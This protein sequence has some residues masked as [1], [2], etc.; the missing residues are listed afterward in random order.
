MLLVLAV[1]PVRAARENP[2]SKVIELLDSLTAKIQKE[3]ENED[4]AFKEF[5]AWCKDAATNTGFEIKTATTQKEK[6]SADIDK[7]KGDASAAE[8]KIEELA[9]GISTSEAD[10]KAAT[11][12][13][14][15]ESTNFAKDEAE[16]VDAIDTLGRAIKI[17]E[18][19]MAKNPAAFAQMDT[20]NVNGLVKALSTVVDAAGFSSADKQR[21]TALVQSKDKDEDELFGAP[22]ADVYKS[23]SGGILDVLEDLKEKAEEQLSQ[24]RKAETNAKHNYEMLKQSLEDQMGA[25]TKDLNEEKQAL[26]AAKEGQATSEKDLAMTE[27]SLADLESKLETAQ[28]DCQ[29]TGADHEASVASRAEELKAIATAKKVL[30]D[31]TAGAETQAYSLLQLN[32]GSSVSSKLHT[33]ADLANIEVVT[34]VK[35]LAKEYHSSA[36][37][38]LASRISAVVKYGSAAG[39]DPFVKVKALI[40]D[41]IA[42][43]EAEASSEADEKAYCDDQMAKTEEKKQELEFDISKLT[44]KIDVASS[45]SAALKEDVKELQADLATLAKE[46]LEMD[47][48]RS[49]THANY[50]QAKADLEAGLQGV[51]KALSVLREYYGSGAAAAMIQGTMAQPAVPEYHEKASGAGSSIIGLLEV[52]ESDF[53]KSLA[54]EETEESDAQTQYEKVSQENEISKTMKSQDVTYKVKEFKSLD[55]QVSELTS[56]KETAGTELQAVL[57]YYSK[58]K[59]RCIAKPET[60]EERK[61]RRESEISGLKEALSILESET[62]FTQRAR[63]GGSRGIFL[64]I[65]Q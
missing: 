33:R 53:A 29:Q 26:S 37:A 46:Q 51:R 22:E 7:L 24:L 31:T 5:M 23:K 11:T 55:K 62:A 39:E 52:V 1:A 21:L 9:A 50:V 41:L 4:K 43:L 38:Q 28:T 57:E 60:Y 65:N 12:I 56:D 49:E 64:G 16:L 45:R 3:G 10:L 40:S 61:R 13:R 14:K 63:K 17:I 42:K 58:I 30:T 36:L 25:D 59:D 47:R 35:K 6:L 2:L 8:T 20:S 54:S 15:S 44:S 48:I 18:R 19:E 32:G 34:L 27:K